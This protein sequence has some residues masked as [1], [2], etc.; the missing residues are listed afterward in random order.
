MLYYGTRKFLRLVRFRECAKSAAWVPAAWSL[1][2]GALVQ[3]CSITMRIKDCGGG[4]GRGS[5]IRVYGILLADA[6][7]YSSAVAS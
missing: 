3:A 1:Q 7:V 2:P 4:E 5:Q 6:V